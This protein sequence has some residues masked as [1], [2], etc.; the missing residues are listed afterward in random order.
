MH[1]FCFQQIAEIESQ[2]PE[3]E[4]EM[5]H[6]QNEIEEKETQKDRITYEFHE[7]SEE[8]KKV[9]D[10][11]LLLRS[12]V[13]NLN[14]EIQNF[15]REKKS[16]QELEV[17]DPEHWERVFVEKSESI[18]RAKAENSQLSADITRFLNPP[19]LMTVIQLFLEHTKSI[20]AI[21]RSQNSSRSAQKL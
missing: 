15:S 8:K 11:A 6:L 2:R 9:E 7:I 1:Q 10:D 17:T 19:R 5:K 4:A 21:W 14:Q 3:R 12:N 13:A 16:L 20:L 18:E